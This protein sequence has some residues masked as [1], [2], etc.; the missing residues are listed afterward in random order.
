MTP[1]IPL[2]SGD[3][4][5]GTDRYREDRQAGAGFAV[6]KLDASFLRTVAIERQA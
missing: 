2:I 1:Q 5:T 3:S 4:G 6:R